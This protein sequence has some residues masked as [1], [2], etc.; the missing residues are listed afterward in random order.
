M[1]IGFWIEKGFST[2]YTRSKTCLPPLGAL[3]VATMASKE[4]DVLV[5][6]GDALEMDLSACKQKFERFHPDLIAT[7]IDSSMLR[8]KMDKL[9]RLRRDLNCYTV[10]GGP[11]P[12]VFPHEMAKQ[13]SVDFAISGEGE[14]TLLELCKH[15]EKE[16]P[17]PRGCYKQNSKDG[18]ILSSGTPKRITNL[19]KLPFPDWLL[20]PYYKYFSPDSLDNPTATMVTC[21]GCYFACTFCSCP[22]IWQQR[23]TYRSISNVLDEMEKLEDFGFKEINF[24]DNLFGGG[25]QRAVKL[26]NTMNERGIDI[27]WLCNTHP[28]MVSKEVAKALKDAGCHQVFLGCES[29]DDSVLKR[30]KKNLSISEVIKAVKLLCHAK[31]TAS[32][33]FIIGFPFETE[34]SAQRTLDFAEKLKRIGDVKIQF[35]LYNPLPDS[36]IYNVYSLYGSYPL[37]IHPKCINLKNAKKDPYPYLKWINWMKNKGLE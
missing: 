17:L 21:R 29:S 15:I 23:V 18:G 27:P 2:N 33:G 26:C 20:V 25:P 36:H 34:E 5:V 12:T 9:G 30:L 35:S 16:T 11:H 32:V 10:V 1:K 22:Q 37:G 4:H 13:P 28:K 6:D 8:E 14:Y 7:Y 24:T 31:I 3:Y 19:D